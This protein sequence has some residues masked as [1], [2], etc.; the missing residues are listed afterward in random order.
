MM[1]TTSAIGTR[2]FSFEATTNGMPAIIVQVTELL[3]SYMIWVGVV[4]ADVGASPGTA[5]IER[6]AATQGSLA[7]D[8]A[9]AMPPSSVSTKTMIIHRANPWQCP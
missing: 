1:P 8:W 7:K 2:S 5:M 4:D 9:C 6:L 3:Q